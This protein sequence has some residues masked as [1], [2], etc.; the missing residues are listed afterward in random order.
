[1]T[2]EPDTT[3]TLIAITPTTF[4]T[5]EDYEEWCEVCEAAA[6]EASYHMD[7]RNG[8][9]VTEIPAWEDIV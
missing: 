6:D 7:E 8:C 3:A 2:V 9:A 5:P 4:V 1:M